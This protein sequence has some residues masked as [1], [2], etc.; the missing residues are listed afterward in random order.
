M[1]LTSQIRWNHLHLDIPHHWEVIVKDKRHLILEHELKPVA[2]LRWQPA[3]RN[4]SGPSSK[5]IARQLDPGHRWSRRPELI[6][7]APISLRSKFSVE[8]FVSDHASEGTVLQLTC[9]SC[10]TILLINI[11]DASLHFLEA[12]PFVFE[13]LNCHPSESEIA[14]WQIQ[15][16]FFSL[17][18]GFALDRSSFRFGLTTL[19][20]TTKESELYL[21]RLAPASQHLQQNSLS[22]LF[23]SFSSAPPAYQ[24]S[25]A[26]SAL[27][28]RYEPKLIEYLWSRIRRRKL[29]QVS[30]FIHFS[31]HD[32]ILGYSI[33][34]RK[35]IEPW[36]QTMMEDGY[37][38]IEK[39]EEAD[40]PDA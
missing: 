37:G 34:S 21:C 40:T 16:F 30:S 8:I 9:K 26:P 32:R 31:S 22:A 39:K 24:Q 19:R 12:Y 36:V 6:D 23:Q 29:Y 2:E 7:S 28:F 20:F 33:K 38:I 4:R 10:A 18:D 11:H 27:H 35:P 14:N 25:D 13:S 1:P 5:K 17:P 3:G 15:D